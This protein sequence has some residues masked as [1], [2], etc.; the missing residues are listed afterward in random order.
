MGRLLGLELNNF[1]SYKGV[2]NVGFGESNFTSIIGPNGSGKSNMMDAI[3]FVLGVQSSHLRSNVLKDLIYRG[4]LSG[5]DEDN[6]NE[7]VNPN[8]AYVKA[9]Y[10][11]EDVT[12]ELMRSISNSGDSTYKINNKTVS[13]KQYTSFLEDENI[14]IKAKNFLV[15]QGDVE[16]IASQSTTDLTKLFEEVSGSIQ[17][18]KEYEEL[19]EKVEKLSQSTAESIKNRRRI[20][21]EI[22]VY[23]DGITKDEKYKAQLEKRRN[24]LVYSSLWQ[25]YHLDEKKSQSK[26]KLKEAKSK[27][28]K[29]KEK[30]ANEEKILQKA[31]NSIVK[32]TAAITKY[33]NK[34]EY[35]SK[36]KEKLA[37]QLI[38]IKVSQR[39]TTKKIS[40]IERR[41]EGIERDIERQKSY[42]ERYESQLKVVTKSKESFELEIKESAK[43]F[44]KYR[45]SDEDLVTYDALSEKYLSSGGFDIDTKISLLNNDKQETSD[46]VAM[47]KNRIELA[48]S[49]IADDLVLQGERLELEISELTS[50][51]NEK[52]SLHSQKVSE[53]KTLQGEIESTSN[54]E[55]DLNY[56]LRETLVKLDDLS[57]SQRESTNERKLRENVSMLRRLFPG[58]RG[59]VSDLCQPKKEKYALAVSTILGKNFDSIITDNISVAQEC[60]AYLKKQR[61]GVAS[62]IPLESIE[63]EV[64]TLPFSDG[65]GCILTINAIEY[66]PEY[67]RAMQYVCSDSIICDTLTIAKDLKWK[68]NVKSKL[69][70]LEGALIH[71]AGLMTGGI[72]RDATNRWDKEEFQSLTVLKDKLLSQIEEL[73]T[74]SKSFAIKGRDLESTISLLNTDITSLRSEFTQLNR[75]LEENKV[76]IQYQTDMIDKEFG[77]KLDALNDK[78]KVYDE[79]ISQFENKKEDLQGEIFKEFTNR[80]G[81]TIK[82]YEEH[83]GE[84]R[85]KQAKELQQLQR[86]ILNIENKLQFEQERL[87][88]TEKRFEKGQSELQKTKISLD[89]LETEESELQT[90]IEEID[91]E[92]ETQRTEIDEMQKAL[93]S[94]LKDISFIED[95]LNEVS[96]SLEISKREKLGFND[97]IEKVDLEKIGIYKNCKISGIELPITSAITLENLPNDKIDND[98][99]LIS[100]E[101]EVDYDELPAEYKESGNEAVGQ[102]I[103]KEIK[104]AEEKLME[105]QPNSKAVERY[106]EAKDKFDEIDKETEGLKKKERKLLTQFVN[107]KKKRKELFEKAFEYVNEH[108]D[109]IYRELTKNP[110]SSVELAGGNASLTLEDEDEPYNGGVK[111]HATPPLKRFKDMEYLSGGEKTVAA[112]ALLFA[113]NSYQ[114]SPFFVLDEID[115]ALDITNVERIATYIQRHGNPELQFIVISLKNS[116]FEKSEALV[117]IYRHQKENSS[118]IIT[119]N[120]TNYV[121]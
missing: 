2:V 85:R 96:N 12:H 61:A 60:I 95:S 106:D 118:R 21:N 22:K 90:Q 74:S 3:S 77:P 115:A 116:M 81:F 25:L 75:A 97:D 46:E 93:D 105:L 89:S 41:I 66:E 14:L 84:I 6:N 43:N 4:F 19:K 73:S 83:S 32:D 20:N 8:S 18:K 94:K 92:L 80:L 87:A 76:E 24:L 79:E 108:I 15:F 35:R 11:K 39:N 57:A 70:T 121:N 40:N 62:F 86:Q 5:D 111:Y 33:K 30:L 27:V 109:P 112:L 53:L 29:L 56:K 117:G 42:V 99:I 49:K 68:H 23:K 59:L 26:N 119:L 67:E 34:L 38:P 71:K 1:K 17:Y 54:K 88:S 72:L 37:S 13:Y 52:N 58:V 9:F 45:L 55:Y 65:Q 113:I 78:I 69:V 98:T 110:N 31:K 10:Q 102:K 36:E 51:L 82:E 7:D 50:S 64:P 114:P 47:F 16:Q 28:S 107:I 91:N 44:D 48:K 103:E 100:N 120:L 104:D 101:I 63:S